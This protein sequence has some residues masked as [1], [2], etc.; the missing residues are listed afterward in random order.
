MKPQEYA[1]Y[2]RDEMKCQHPIGQIRIADDNTGAYCRKCCDWISV[3]DVANSA[4]LATL[5]AQNAELKHLLFLVTAPLEKVAGSQNVP[6]MMADLAEDAL[7]LIRS[8]LAKYG[9][10]N[11]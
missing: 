2:N 10:D 7:R 3:T 5:R 8:T 6:N 4:E 9:D 1:I 11:A